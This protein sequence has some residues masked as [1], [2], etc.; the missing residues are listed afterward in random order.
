MKSLLMSDG[1]C[2]SAA[3]ASERRALT[4]RRAV[5]LD[6]DRL[7][8]LGR[9]FRAQTPYRE[10]VVDDREHMQRFADTMFSL[11][12]DGLV[13]VA[14]DAAGVLQGMWVGTV[15]V[16]PIAGV[17]MATE[18]LW[19][20]EPEVRGTG[21]ARRLLAMAETWARERGAI[22]MQLGSWHDRLDRFY[23]RLGY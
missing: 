17:R 9:H 19:W 15:F 12:E 16:H 3:T 18:L 2:D 10:S 14:E 7:I 1:A 4:I 20:M 6:R 8:D 21:T 22:R 11:Q 5:P 13:L 23:V